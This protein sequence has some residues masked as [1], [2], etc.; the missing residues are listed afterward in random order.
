MNDK[1]YDKAFK[2]IKL[3]QYN[4]DSFSKDPHCKVGA[5][6]LTDDFSTILACGINGFP[7]KMNDDLQ[8][9]WERPAKY[10]LISHAESNAVANAARKGTVLDGSVMAVTKFPCST[11]TKLIIQAGIKKIYAPEPDYTCGKWGDDARIS[12]AM[13]EEVGIPVVKFQQTLK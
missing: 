7:R 13:L 6:V 2:Y 9:R 1:E 11:C 8:E 5:I 4:A 10:A 12:E 3:A